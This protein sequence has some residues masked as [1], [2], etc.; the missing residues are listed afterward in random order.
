MGYE[1]F[2]L[3]I[4]DKVGHVKMNR[5]DRANSMIAAFWRELPQIVDELSA[6][7]S[8][9]AMVLSA[10]G[11]HF[12]SGMDLEVFAGNETVGTNAK[13]RGHRS[14]RNEGFRS[15]ALKLQDSFTA[16]ERARMPVLCAIQ[17]ACI[18]GGIDM[19]SAADMRYADESA[20]FSIQEINIAMTADVGTLQRMPKLVAEGIVRELAYTG[21]RWSA[22][23]ALAAGFVNA[24]YPDHAT[25]LD[26][27]M[28]VAA[29]IAS[30]SPMAVW[31]TKQTMNFARDHSVADSLEY[32]ANWNAAMFD[33]DDMAEAFAA[34]VEG[35]E[36]EF[37]D[38][39]PLAE[40]L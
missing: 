15:M 14:R 4:V 27:V 7:G 17:G 38:L 32:I 34:K 19:V 33:T 12:C 8:V 21:R 28:G 37:P 26:A 24:V 25:M 6:S 29:E 2:D 36:A 5:P 1:C 16:L 22:A 30:K 13:S 40:G 23:E 18:G 39:N 20:Y 10:E 9:R 35:R 3:E 11:K 31:G